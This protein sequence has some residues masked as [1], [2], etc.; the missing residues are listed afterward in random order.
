MQPRIPSWP[1]ALA[2][3]PRERCRTPCYRQHSCL[4]QTGPTTLQPTC[5]PSKANAPDWNGCPTLQHHV[6]P[7][8]GP[9]KVCPPLWILLCSSSSL[10]SLTW[11]VVD[12]AWT[13]KWNLACVS[14]VVI[15]SFVSEFSLQLD[16]KLLG[17]GNHDLY[18][19]QGWR[20]RCWR[21]AHPQQSSFF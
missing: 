11:I 10:R 12:A 9:T 7:S 18:V 13:T 15:H 21:Q 17:D 2:A 19:T 20:Q 5:Q 8:Q 6:R 16:Y 4:G 3:L 1:R 14:W